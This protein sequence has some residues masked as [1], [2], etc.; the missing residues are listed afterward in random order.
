MND[1]SV[2]SLLSFLGLLTV[3]FGV[4]QCFFGYRIYRTIIAILGFCLGAGAGAGIAIATRS[5]ELSVILGGVLGGV[6]GASL[7]WALYLVGV[8]LIGAIGGGLLGILIAEAT[9]SNDAA[10]ALV[11][12]MAIGGGVAALMI[13]KFVI[14]VSTAFGGSANMLIGATWMFAPGISLRDAS[15]AWRTIGVDAE[16]IPL[17][18]IALAIAGIWAQYRQPRTSEAAAPA[19]P[20]EHEVTSVDALPAPVAVSSRQVADSAS[21]VAPE[22]VWRP[23]AP[24]RPPGAEP[25]PTANDDSPPTRGP[26]WPG[27]A[28]PTASSPFPLTSQLPT[29]SSEHQPAPRIRHNQS[30]PPTTQRPSSHPNGSAPGRQRDEGAWSWPEKR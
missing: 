27:S 30:A 7:L 25:V 26:A 23:E 3:A 12:V 24:I 4:A 29:Q 6:I 14:I 17:L 18:W 19:R 28:H 11:I 13:Q 8:F 5:G 2:S 21:R 22:R 9:S 10:A 15:R 20:V 1:N 16:I